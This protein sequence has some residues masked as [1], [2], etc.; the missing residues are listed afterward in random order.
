M[1]FCVLP[2]CLKSVNAKAISMTVYTM[3]PDFLFSLVPEFRAEAQSDASE[4]RPMLAIPTTSQLS[5]DKQLYNTQSTSL[6]HYEVAIMHV[7]CVCRDCTETDILA[8]L[9]PL[10]VSDAQRMANLWMLPVP[11]SHPWQNSQRTYGVDNMCNY[12]IMS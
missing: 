12:Y 3:R 1:L 11:L 4:Y 9:Q 10:V 2:M 7:K 5:K 8:S 6:S